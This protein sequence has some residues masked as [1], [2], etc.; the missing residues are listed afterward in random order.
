MRNG[1]IGQGDADHPFLSYVSRFL[2][3]LLNISP[4]SHADT[5]LSFT[6]THNYQRLKAQAS[7][8]F[9]CPRNSINGNG[10]LLKELI[11]SRPVITT[12][13]PTAT[14]SSSRTITGP[15]GHAVTAKVI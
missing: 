10:L 14:T 2:D 11:I 7:T 8:A 9:Y 1:L 3:S 5:D 6:I 13:T 4:L 15:T 12:T